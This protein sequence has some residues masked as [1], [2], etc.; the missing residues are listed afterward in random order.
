M[1]WIPF[2]WENTFIKKLLKRLNWRVSKQSE[3]FNGMLS[4]EGSCNICGNETS[5]YYDDERLYRESL[6]C[7]SCLTTSRYR[8]I[9][10]GILR[11][12]RELRGVES[13]SLASLDPKLDLALLKVYDTQV[14][15]YWETCCYPVPDLLSKCEWIDVQKSLYRPREPLGAIL[16][17]NTTNQNLEGL[18][19][20]DE[21]FDVVITS[22]VMEHVRLDDEAHK[23]IRRVL[24]PGG[25]YIFTVP[26]FRQR[27]GT[28]TRVAVVDPSNP[29]MDEFLLE[30]EYHGDANSEDGKAL[31]Y[32]VYGGELDAFLGRLGFDVEYSRLDFPELGIMNTELFFATLSR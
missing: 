5:F 1:V 19:F 9:S 8:S 7:G 27:T 22:D 28:L 30:P 29:E 6:Y 24:K 16:A 18:T 23:E 12:I 17:P 21:T 13:N 26:H 4:H 32:R 14:A 31:S 20:K 15:F 10:R 3:R 25:V 11:A 2:R